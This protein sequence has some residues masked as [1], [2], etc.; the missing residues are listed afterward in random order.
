MI[1]LPTAP[2]A[3]TTLA[4]ALLIPACAGVAEGVAK[5]V[6]E[7]AP[8]ERIQPVSRS[9]DGSPSA[10]LGRAFHAGRRAELRERLVAAGGSGVVIMRG[11]PET[12]DYTTFHQDKNFW[13]LTGVESP[14]ATLVMDLDS[15]RDIL[16]LPEPNPVKEGWEGEIW[17]SDDDWVPPLTGI[18][19]LRP[20][21]Q[22]MA[23]LGVMLPAAGTAWV[24]KSPWVTVSGC[25][26]RAI[27]ANKR[28]AADPLD[29]RPS[30]EAA[31]AGNLA[32]SFGVKVEDLAP[33]LG[34]IRRVK[35]KEELSALRRAADS[36]ALALMEAMAS[37]TDGVGEWEIDAL[38]GFE[39]ELEG[40]GGEAYHAIV[41]S[42][43]NSCVLHYNTSARTMHDGELLLVDAG[44]EVDHYATDI[45]RTWPVNGKFSPEQAAQYDAVLAA[46]AAGIAAVRPGITLAEIGGVA[47]GVLRDMGYGDMIRHGVCHY[48]G[49]E[50]HDTGSYGKPLEPG[51]VFT[52]EPGLYDEETGFGIRIEDV[53]VVTEDGYEVITASVPRDRAAIEA[54]MAKEGRLQAR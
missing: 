18:A 29:G 21:G 33:T 16:F 31:L 48:V 19:E 36:G 43:P 8:R 12:R 51:V 7:V 4:L 6:A 25:F 30:R 38:L 2:R 1:S 44:P 24:S 13:Y 20:A 49:M 26:D 53:V 47:N 28:Q 10:G 27:P 54:I 50:V 52:V 37:T 34:E 5:G 39:Q 35:T 42:G 15:E 14:D 32:E 46:Q 45:T 23:T 3:L 9:G 17:D 11:L 41:G 40:A 22:L